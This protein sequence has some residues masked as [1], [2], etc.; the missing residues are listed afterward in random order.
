MKYYNYCFNTNPYKHSKDDFIYSEV[1][2]RIESI[3]YN[4]HCDFLISKQIINGAYW[5]SWRK[6]PFSNHIA[7]GFVFMK[8]MRQNQIL[9]SYKP[10]ERITTVFNSNKWNKIK[11]YSI[12]LK[13]PKL[14]IAKDNKITISTHSECPSMIEKICKKY[15]NYF[16]TIN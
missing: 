1:D 10:S 14:N 2:K 16:F 8:A 13:S 3:G 4:F 15:N 7:N 6:F 12:L 5:G 11:V 9:G